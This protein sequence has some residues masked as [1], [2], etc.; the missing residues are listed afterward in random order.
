MLMTVLGTT[1]FAQPLQ[2]TKDI[3][4]GWQRRFEVGAF[5][6]TLFTAGCGDD[7]LKRHDG[8]PVVS[9]NYQD[10]GISMKQHRTAHKTGSVMALSLY[11]V[12]AW[13]LY[14][15]NL[16]R[17]HLEFRHK[18]HNNL[19]LTTIGGVVSAGIVGALSSNAYRN[20]HPQQAGDYARLMKQI[21]YAT[22]AVGFADIVLFGRHDNTSIIGVKINF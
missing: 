2:T 19:F 15:I 8:D 14:K 5:A 21:G 9:K 11:M 10:M 18:A 1:I 6:S 3:H 20:S 4:D 22:L 7:L 13:Q 17:D 12:S 16:N